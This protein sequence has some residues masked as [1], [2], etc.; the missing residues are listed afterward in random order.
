MN[1]ISVLGFAQGGDLLARAKWHNPTLTISEHDERLLAELSPL[2]TAKFLNETYGVPLVDTFPDDSAHDWD[3]PD[4]W[5]GMVTVVMRSRIQR[6]CRVSFDGLP[7]LDARVL[8]DDMVRSGL[9]SWEFTTIDE[10]AGV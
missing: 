8:V 7:V 5:K 1:P 3:V 2:E 9:W 6:S 10:T 4:N